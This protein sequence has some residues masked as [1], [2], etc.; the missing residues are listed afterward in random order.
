MTEDRVKVTIM[1]IL[2]AVVLIAALAA[3]SSAKQGGTPAAT[4]PAPTATSS[5]M[6]WQSER[7]IKEP[8]TATVSITQAV[9]LGDLATQQVKVV[10][11]P[12][13]LSAGTVVTVTNLENP[14]SMDSSVGIPVGSPVSIS[15]GDKPVRLNEL[16]TVAL[17][18][19]Q[20]KL[21]SG[22]RAE[23]LWA[24]FYDGTAWQLFR[25]DSVDLG[26][27]TMTFATDH[28]TGFGTVKIDVE[29]HIAQIIHSKVAAEVVQ[30]D[31][32]NNITDQLAGQAIDHI[33]VDRLGMSEEGWKT[34]VLQSLLK[35]DEWGDIV[36]QMKEK[37]FD[38]V[39]VAETINVFVGKKI[40]EN[41]EESAL[42]GALGRVTEGTGLVKAGSEAAAYVAE[43]R[44]ADAARI[45]GEEIASDTVVYKAV[46]AAS[47]VINWR[48][49]LWKDGKMEAAYKAYRNG[50]STDNPNGYDLAPRDFEALW[51]QV[52]GI[53][54]RLESE[55]VAREETRRQQEGLKPLTEA[56][57][58]SIRAGV[59]TDM[60]KQFEDRAKLD[61]QIAK[62][63]A[64]AK[65]LLA[66]PDM[67][68]L[69]DQTI[70]FDS[71]YTM[72]RKVNVILRVRDTILHDTAGKT[73]KNEEGKVVSVTSQDIVDL[74]RAHRGQASAA[75][76]VKAY[77]ALLKKKFGVDLNATPTPAA[78]QGTWVFVER[79][80]EPFVAWEGAQGVGRAGISGRSI[81]ATVAWR[82]NTSAWTCG[83][84]EP[85][86]QMKA[87][88]K[89]SGTL[90][91]A[92]AGSGQTAVL[93]GEDLIGKEKV[94]GKIQ[95]TAL[96]T[97]WI[98]TGGTPES[99]VRPPDLNASA[100][101]DAARSQSFSWT[102]P[103][104]NLP[105]ARPQLVVTAYCSASIYFDQGG[106]EGASAGVKYT[107]KWQP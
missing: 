3:C 4:K 11:P 35:D 31:V 46:T 96:L 56:E 99:W 8:L 48:I 37:G 2:A 52:K 36:A 71:S 34:K 61:D 24:A 58:N 53:D 87:G 82:Q 15:V 78:A 63:E 21:P 29:E 28:L 65:K 80:E 106:T 41:V 74:I 27:G 1:S 25:P 67:R 70:Y 23:E 92:D 64:E 12:G 91:L 97:T 40:V 66:Y 84:P 42:S 62:E 90:N 33:L 77:R 6:S 10:I 38:G 20:S 60:K 49:E 16:M 39:K 19:D 22:T 88:G 59:K 9:T 13:T 93:V 7:P 44:Y 45:I 18:F 95:G 14:P 47:E 32:L 104:P 102:V 73:L 79:K 86:Q 89:W 68:R 57:A 69:M 26:A 100:D 72:E 75:E 30:K 98:E 55:A 103:D 94:A 54:T 85:P 51:N 17:K 81:T 43:G 5:A 50:A 107:Y 101:A 76:G 105:N 83:W